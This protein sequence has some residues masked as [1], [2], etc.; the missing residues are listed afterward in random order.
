MIQAFPAYSQI[1]NG[2]DSEITHEGRRVKLTLLPHDPHEFLTITGYNE[3]GLTVKDFISSGFPD[4]EDCELIQLERTDKLGKKTINISY[5][6]QLK[7]ADTCRAFFEKVKTGDVEPK[8]G[9]I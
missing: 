5:N 9:N 4:V 1:A 3:V 8:S 2:K 7:D 6:I